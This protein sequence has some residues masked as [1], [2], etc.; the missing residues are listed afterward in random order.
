VPV[1]DLTL[2]V[3]GG[4]GQ[5]GTDLAGRARG[6]VWAP[7]SAELD[8]TDPAA[9]T[10]VVSKLVDAAHRQGRPAV[11]INAA[12][13]TAVDAAE[14]DQDRAYAVNVDGARLLAETCAQQDIP[15]VQVS[16]DY[17]FSEPRERP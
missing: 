3:A 16:T 5:L 1:T 10:E 15:L 7:G 17:V 2:L 6:V 13:Y 8:V 9:V 4:R 12:A 14:S 11:V